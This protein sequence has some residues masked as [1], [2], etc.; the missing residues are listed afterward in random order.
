MKFSLQKTE[1][2]GLAVTNTEN[3]ARNTKY[4][5]VIK[6]IITL[7]NIS[8]NSKVAKLGFLWLYILPLGYPLSHRV[9][10]LL[11][12][13]SYTGSLVPDKELEFILHRE[14]SQA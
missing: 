8:V 2:S 1:N 4:D 14:F 12:V 5:Y 9:W 7:T 10:V 11:A 3:S 6:K 13:F